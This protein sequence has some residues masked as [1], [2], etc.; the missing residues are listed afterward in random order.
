MLWEQDVAGSNPVI[1]IYLTAVH[2]CGVALIAAKLLR[3]H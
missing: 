3:F 1:P 2:Q